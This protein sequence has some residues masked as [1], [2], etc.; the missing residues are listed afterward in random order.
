LRVHAAGGLAL[1]VTA[2]LGGG[3]QPH[4]AVDAATLGLGSAAPDAIGLLA[5]EGLRE[6]PRLGRV[7][8]ILVSS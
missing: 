1:L 2:Q 7:S 3:G 4:L 8:K 5:G 6:A